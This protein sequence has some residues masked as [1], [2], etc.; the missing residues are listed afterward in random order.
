[1]R[2]STLQQ[3]SG[4]PEAAT[5]RRT[6]FAHH[7]VFG[8]VASF[9]DCG[10]A[11]L[12]ASEKYGASGGVRPGHRMS[13]CKLKG[14]ARLVDEGKTKAHAFDVDDVVSPFSP[15][16]KILFQIVFS[17]WVTLSEHKWVILAERRGR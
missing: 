10:Q 13:G 9:F 14:Y 3:S 11:G 2:T 17:V 12:Q 4:S 15:A 5:K 6:D 1:M 16:G 8:G 7:P